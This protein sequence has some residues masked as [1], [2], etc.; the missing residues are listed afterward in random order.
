MNDSLEVTANDTYSFNVDKN[1]PATFGT[2]RFS[3]VIR[4]DPALGVHLLN[5]TAVKATNGAE[6]GWV[7][8]NEADYTSYT[9]ERSSDNGVTFI[10]LDEIMSSGLGTYSF[11]DKTPPV[12]ADQYRLKITDLNGV[13]T[14]SKIVTLIYGKGNSGVVAN[15]INVYPNPASSIIG[16][17]VTQNTLPSSNAGT[18]SYKIIITNSSGSIVK[19]A[20]SAGATWG[21]NVSGFLPGTYVIQVLNTSNN[22]LV[23][24]TKFT[25]I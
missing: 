21:G 4:Q 18:V 24:K 13:I 22:G 5:F 9:V 12:A 15:I 8:E 25:K 10:A 17:S 20:F 19:T 14:Y 1:N 2:H 6:I 3:L 11:L 16:L 23:G 7:T